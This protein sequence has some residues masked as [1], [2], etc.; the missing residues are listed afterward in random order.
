[1][2]PCYMKFWRCARAHCAF[3]FCLLLILATSQALAQPRARAKISQ[4]PLTVRVNNIAIG[5]EY[6][7]R[8]LTGFFPDPILTT[9]SITD[10]NG[11]P[12]T[13]LADTARWLGPQ[14][15]TENGQSISQIWQ[16]IS[17]YHR[18]NPAF[19][20]DPNLYNQTPAPLFTEVRRAAGFPTST[21]LVMDVSGSIK[22]E[23]EDAKL[24][25]LTFLRQLRPI[26]RVGLIK[27]CGIVSE[28]Y[29]F[30]NDKAPLITSVATADTCL[31]TA[32]YASLM[33]AIQETKR[34]TNRRAI[35]LYTDGLN[36]RGGATPEAVID[37]AR[38]YNI[39]IHT[40]A[41]GTEASVDTLG[42]IAAATGGLFFQASRAAE[43]ND[44]YQLL[45]GW[46]QNFYVMA[47]TS[48]DPNYNGTWRVVEVTVERNGDSGRGIGQ[49]FVPGTPRWR[50]TDVEV[51]MASDTELETLA[52]NKIFNAVTLG[53]PFRYNINLRNLGPERAE[54]VRLTQVLPDSVRFVSATPP[55]SSANANSLV[56]EVGRLEAG[57]VA[58]IAV[59]VDFVQQ[60]P[61]ALDRL[62]S[63]VDLLAANDTLRANNAATDTVLVLFPPLPTID[64]AVAQ[65]PQTDSSAT[66]G[67][68]IFPVVRRNREYNYTITVKNES[69]ITA[70]NVKVRD[71]LPAEVAQAHDFEIAPEN[72]NA[73][74]LQWT[75][76]S[77]GPRQSLSFKFQATV[78]ANLPVGI[79]PLV[80]KVEVEAENEDQTQLGNNSATTTVYYI[81]RPVGIPTPLIAAMP[82]VVDIGEPA[83][84][85]VQFPV[86]VRSWDLWVYF[87]DGQVD[88]KF[89][90]DYIST[91]LTSDYAQPLTLRTEAWHDVPVPFTNT[92]LFTAVKRERIIFEIRTMDVFGNA[93]SD[94]ASIIVQSGNDMYLDRNVYEP[95]VTLDRLRINFKLSSNR[96]ARLEVFDVN[97]KRVCNI[98]ETFFNAGWN[99][100]DWNGVAENGQKVGSGVYLVTLRSGEYNSWKKFIIAR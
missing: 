55:I 66:V 46:I 15:T 74:P 49:Y 63:R 32:I 51:T 42:Q 96:V 47:H 92:R 13:G 19:P 94:T 56:W 67:N 38:A 25:V 31:A 48:P 83:R 95:G 73:R 78:I 10:Q 23:L 89:A 52:N 5:G 98:T 87:A 40:I 33:T 90:D 2:T 26:D 62:I 85:Q 79:H 64:G 76:A 71:F 100:F 61:R 20:P 58:S 65:T 59:A 21:M 54:N 3:S 1:M 80:N 97:G 8:G 27:F 88:Q 39:P 16:Q 70:R 37:S 43:F 36:N 17:E 30:T 68:Q 28:L 18:D 69:A 93:A 12:V 82:P 99:F 53:E 77:L 35:I 86:Q 75:F 91:T 4:A 41:L 29:P 34:E 72:G 84:V 81:I 60:V 7:L 44:I 22:N 45:L 50:A 14:D 24:A 57:S 6:S 11:F 9:I